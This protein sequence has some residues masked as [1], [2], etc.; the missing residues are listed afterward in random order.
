[1]II[2]KNNVFVFQ[3]VAMLIFQN[4]SKR[5]RKHDKRFQ[6]CNAVPAQ[7]HR[8]PAQPSGDWSPFLGIAFVVTFDYI[9][10]FDA[11]ARVQ[12]LIA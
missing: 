10:E 4:R 1:M 7:S 12:E 11:D 8:W 5:H 6:T 2:F 9:S 3:N